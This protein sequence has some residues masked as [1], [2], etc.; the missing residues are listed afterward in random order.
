MPLPTASTL[1]PR[2]LTIVLALIALAAIALPLAVALNPPKIPVQQRHALQ[3]TRIVS[4]AELPPVEPV[5]F[6]DLAPDDARAWNAQVPFVAGPN[7][8]ARPFKLSGTAEDRARATDCMAAA[9][10]YEAGDDPVGER[11]VGQVVINRA[12]HPAFPKTICGVVF[13]GSERR[14]GCQFTFTCDGAMARAPNPAAWERARKLAAVALDGAVFAK[15]GYA[16]HYH[17]DWVVPYWSASL[18][19]IAAVDTHLFFRWTGWWGTP[20]AFRR[21]VSGTEPVISQ[22]AALSPAHGMALALDGASAI[23]LSAE[24]LL[25]TRT[26]TSLADGSFLVALDRKFGADQLPALAQATCAQRDY[27]KLLGW[28]DARDKPKTLPATPEQM[29]A[30]AFSYLRDKAKGFDK[31]L[32]NCGVFK[33]ADPRECMKVQFM[34]ASKPAAA[35]ISM[36]APRATLSLPAVTPVSSPTT[37]PTPTPRPSATPAK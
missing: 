22:L 25:A 37:R 26:E 28:L 32:W 16:T 15:V 10:L 7:P 30:M 1:P 20:P 18:D 19:K 6:Q 17:T 24:A 23:T 4:P 31:A 2:W 14:T 27:C 29:S 36:P 5:R 34:P 3:P 21:T 13:Q 33:R 9:M 12:R 11:A 35:E 8:A